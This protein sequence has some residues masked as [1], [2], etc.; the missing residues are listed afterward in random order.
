MAIEGLLL[1]DVNLSLNELLKTASRKELD[2]LA[3]I[4]TDKGKGRISLSGEKKV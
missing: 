2:M 3:D 4:I 1:I